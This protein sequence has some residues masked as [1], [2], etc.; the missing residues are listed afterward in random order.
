M[1]NWREILIRPRILRAQIVSV[2][3]FQL[4]L[5]IILGPLCS[6]LVPFQLSF[7]IERF[8]GIVGKWSEGDS[9]QFLMHYW[10]DFI[11]PILYS[12][13]IASLS[14][15]FSRGQNTKI[16]SNPFILPVIICL[17]DFVEN[18]LHILIFLPQ[19][20][21]APS[22]IFYAS[23]FSLIKWSLIFFC[24]ISIVLLWKNRANVPGVGTK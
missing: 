2:I 8:T 15:F 6:D 18:I 14:I 12:C 5:L 1:I 20:N 13:L 21:P 9:S 17:S 23:L 3:V 16:G 10:L 22:L 7:T 11:Y 4:G 19:F 24:L